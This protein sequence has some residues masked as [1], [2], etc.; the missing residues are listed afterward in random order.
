MLWISTANTRCLQGLLIAIFTSLA[1][2]SAL[3]E[4]EALS[5]AQQNAL[6]HKYCAVCH[7]DASRNGGLSLEYYD[8]GKPDPAL[9][10]MLLSKLR[11]GAMGAAGLGT[12]DK[13]TGDAWVAATAAQ[14]EGAKHWNMIRKDEAGSKVLVASTIRE[15]PPRIPGTDS[16]V[17]RLT[18]TC[19]ASKRQGEMQL[20]WSPQP[21]TDRTFW[22]AVDG[23]P[24]IAQRLEGKENMGNGAA[25]TS[26]RAGIILHVTAPQRSLTVKDLF[27]NE[28]VVFPMD[29]LDHQIGQ[30][31]AACFPR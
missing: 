3:G 17:Y 14:A 29:E 5:I 19:D 25:G 31:L 2:K 21:Q 9:A 20:T 7:T 11:A 18:V 1:A 26:G 16:P 22:V 4:N 27:P 15:V 13:A 28:V 24:G 12:P 30:E 6:V 23:Q 8:A 10:A